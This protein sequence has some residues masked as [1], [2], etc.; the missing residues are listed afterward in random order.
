MTTPTDTLRDLITAHSSRVAL[1]SE[2]A[3]EF[4]SSFKMIQLLKPFDVLDVF[5][6]D[7]IQEVGR[8]IYANFCFFGDGIFGEV[9]NSKEPSN[10]DVKDAFVV[11]LKEGLVKVAIQD[12]DNYDF[13]HATET[14]RVTI[15][16]YG[17]N[18]ESFFLNAAGLNCDVLCRIYRDRLLSLL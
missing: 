7:Y 13:V 9:T 10:R 4:V 18:G 14:S 12:Y 15:A 3:E 5:V 11:S 8:R 1:P 16:F 2:V 6:E 17:R